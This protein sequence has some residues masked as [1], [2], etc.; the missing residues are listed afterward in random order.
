[1]ISKHCGDQDRDRDTNDGD[2]GNTSPFD[3]L[4][5]D[6][7]SSSASPTADPRRRLD[8]SECHHKQAG[9]PESSRV[10]GDED[11]DRFQP[12]IHVP[13]LRNSEARSPGPFSDANI[14]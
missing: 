2:G 14:N 10:I 1:M 6:D 9:A 11:R 3:I 7:V 5:S 4:R 13:A 12:T 8:A